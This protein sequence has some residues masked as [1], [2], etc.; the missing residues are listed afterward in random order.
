MQNL[1]VVWTLKP[2]ST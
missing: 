1:T 2:E